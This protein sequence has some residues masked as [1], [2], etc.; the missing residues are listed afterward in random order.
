MDTHMYFYRLRKD[1]WARYAAL[2][3]AFPSHSVPTWE[4]GV[5]V[6]E[7]LFLPFL[8]DM[9]WYSAKQV[10]SRVICTALLNRWGLW[11]CQLWAV[12]PLS[13][14]LYWE[15]ILSGKSMLTSE[16]KAEPWLGKDEARGQGYIVKD[17]VFN[18]RALLHLAKKNL[19]E[20]LT[21][22]NYS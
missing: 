21:K 16:T 9:L 3:P 14:S 8:E 13:P 19:M 11:S 20:D 5:Q 7:H 10:I 6:E 4:V 12:P 15:F 1:R 17:A 2:L 18:R 22:T